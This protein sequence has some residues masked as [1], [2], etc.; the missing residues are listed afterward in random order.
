VIAARAAS[1]VSLKREIA[2][3]GG[4]WLYGVNLIPVGDQVPAVRGEPARTDGTN[5]ANIHGVQRRVAR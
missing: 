3:W 4:G 5:D 1:Q 2:F